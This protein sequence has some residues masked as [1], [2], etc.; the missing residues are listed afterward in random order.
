MLFSF[1]FLLFWLLSASFA[2]AIAQTKG[3]F[4]FGVFLLGLVIGPFALAVAVG[5]APDSYAVLKRSCYGT[6][7]KICK[8]CCT[9]TPT[10]ES[11]CKTCHT[12][13]F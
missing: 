6:N 3:R 8:N 12:N 5:L 10:S 13:F 11:C 4:A 2:S 1:L 7:L 9:A